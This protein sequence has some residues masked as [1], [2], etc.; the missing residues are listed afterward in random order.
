[1][2]NNDMRSMLGIMREL[3]NPKTSL[4]NEQN[5]SSNLDETTVQSIK[6]IFPEN[7]IINNISLTENKQT[8]NVTGQILSLDIEYNMLLKTSINESTCTID[9][10]NMVSEGTSVF[11]VNQ[12]FINSLMDVNN[13]YNAYRDIHKYILDNNVL[14]FD[15]ENTQDDQD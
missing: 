9:M 1:M 4:I 5:I 6:D 3:K 7:I 15:I 13:L 10:G 8:V 12:D 2:K 14:S 11:T